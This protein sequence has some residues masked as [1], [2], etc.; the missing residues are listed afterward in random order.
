MMSGSQSNSPRR[1]SMRPPTA[2]AAPPITVEQ[3]I[4]ALEKVNAWT[5]EPVREA[6]A[7]LVA[8]TEVAVPA[9][10]AAVEA[11]AA[12]PQTKPKKGEPKMPWEDVGGGTKQ[13]LLRLPSELAAKLKYLGG[14]TYGESMNSI[15]MNAIEREVKRMMKE[16][17]F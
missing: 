6:A 17:G 10:P 8:P 13:V 15:A 7:A 5:E 11:V 9:V 16:N 12:Q 1:I 3:G 14:V 4:A 2:L